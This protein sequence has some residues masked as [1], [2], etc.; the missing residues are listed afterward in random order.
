MIKTVIIVSFLVM[1][2]GCLEKNRKVQVDVKGSDKLIVNDSVCTKSVRYA[3]TQ[4]VK[5]LQSCYIMLRDSV[6]DVFIKETARVKTDKLL[7]FRS[8]DGEYSFRLSKDTLKISFLREV[9]KHRYFYRIPDSIYFK[10]DTLI[11]TETVNVFR[12]RENVS[13][14]A[15]DLSEYA[16]QIRRRPTGSI[17]VMYRVN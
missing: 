5:L 3:D 12:K 11:V 4:N 16:I 8:T 1:L 13:D 2:Y 15:F 9:N 7:N 6:S 10:G 17:K 14:I